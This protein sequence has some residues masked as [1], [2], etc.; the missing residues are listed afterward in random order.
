MTKFEVYSMGR[1]QRIHFVG[2]GG[3]GMGGIAEVL[4]NLGYSVSGSDLHLNTITERL[5]KLGV[6]VSKG[7]AAGQVKDCDVVVVSRSEPDTE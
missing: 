2:I 6:T 1:V 5:A 3:V 7:H 4:H